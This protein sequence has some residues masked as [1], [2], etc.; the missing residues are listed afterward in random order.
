MFDKNQLSEEEKAELF[1]FVEEVCDL[2]YEKFESIKS[3]L[4]GYRKKHAPHGACVVS[5]QTL[6][7]INLLS[8]SSEIL[9]G[10]PYLVLLSSFFFQSC[11]LFS[12]KFSF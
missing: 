7:L 5:K 11:D 3:S 8:R 4:P 2:G 6:P 9:F 1:R 12:Y 10:I